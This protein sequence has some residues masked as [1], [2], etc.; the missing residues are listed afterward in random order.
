[1][2]RRGVSPIIAV[3]LMIVIAVAAA[4]VV[5]SFVMGFVGSTTATPTE[6]QAR[7]VVDEANI[8]VWGDNKAV[9]VAFV[10]NVGEVPVHITYIYLLDVNGTLFFANET[11][12]E[13]WSIETT[14]PP[15]VKVDELK[16]VH[17]D[18]NDH[19]PS[20]GRRFLVKVVTAEGAV[21]VSA[22]I[23]FYP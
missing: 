21:A 5:Y 13:T 7:I 15:L 10:R 12:E 16:K 6:M 4:I 1:M 19:F 23:P 3:L 2:K 20:T 22:P 8:T 11:W 9:V 17:M 14:G 18:M